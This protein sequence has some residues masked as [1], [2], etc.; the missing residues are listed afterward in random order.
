MVFSLVLLPTFG[1]GSQ[2]T[3]AQFSELGRRMAAIGHPLDATAG[4]VITDFPIWMAE[5]QRIPTLALPDESP[6]DVLDLAHDPAFTGTHLVILMDKDHGRWPAVL[7]TDVPDADC[8][9]ELDLGAGTANARSAGRRAR[10]RG[11]LP[12]STGP[13]TQRPMEPARAG[14]DQAGGRRDGE[15]R[16]C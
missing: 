5:T 2:D 3:Q 11:R 8:F 16:R 13:Y 14:T 10:L 9:R 7:D 1:T 4:P 15:T 12:V 6:T